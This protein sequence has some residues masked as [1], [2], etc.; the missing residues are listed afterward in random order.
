MADHGGSRFLRVLPFYIQMIYDGHEPEPLLP[1]ALWKCVDQVCEGSGRSR[2]DESDG[3]RYTIAGD[4]VT[5]WC[6]RHWYESVIGESAPYRLLD[7]TDEQYRKES[8]DYKQQLLKDWDI[9][10]G[11]LQSSAAILSDRGLDNEA[12]KLWEAYGYIQSSIQGM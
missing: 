10:R 11:R 12:G 3:M 4:E 6:P 2:C 5:W 1:V 9:V 8:Q 7:M